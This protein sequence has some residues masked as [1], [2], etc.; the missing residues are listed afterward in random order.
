MDRKDH[1]LEWIKEKIL[2][3]PEEPAAESWDKISGS[4]DLEETWQGI[5]E[6]LDLEEVWQ[7]VDTRLHQYEFLQLFE[8]IGYAISGLA[9]VA[10]L[11]GIWW[12]EGTFTG[13]TGREEASAY[14]ISKEVPQG[15]VQKEEELAPSNTSTGRGTKGSAALLGP[16]AAKIPGGTAKKDSLQ[17]SV[18]LAGTARENNRQEAF[19]A[20]ETKPSFAG[21]KKSSLPAFSN[22]RENE[23]VQIAF[24]QA[25]GSSS[26]QEKRLNF[27]DKKAF[28]PFDPAIPEW[29]DLAQVDSL[30]AMPAEREADSL[31]SFSQFPAMVVGIGTT[32]KLSWLMNN[33]TLHAMEKTSLVTAVPAVYSDVFLTYGL[34]VHRNYLLQTE[35]YLLDWSGQRYKEYRNGSYGEVEERLLYRSLGLSLSKAGRQLGFGSMP[36]YSQLNL[37]FYGGMLH[38]GREESVTG[39]LATKDEYSKWHFGLQAGYGYDMYVLDKLLLTYGLRARFD[40]LNIYSGNEVIPAHFRRTRNASLDFNITLKYILKK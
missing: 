3:N 16:A 4:L 5:G 9:V 18:P 35:G 2:T 10:L 15:I 29:P 7:K 25:R 39:T 11:L 19:S 28:L 37:G 34:R 21:T 38:Q 23:Q 20:A 13:A 1:F 40:L 33:K 8:R 24:E 36:V 6:D 32:A 22:R 26:G 31:L 27:A 14:S 12:G 30:T 17:A